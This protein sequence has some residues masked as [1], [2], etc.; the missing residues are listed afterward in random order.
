[1]VGD[2]V[3]VSAFQKAIHAVVKPGHVVVDLGT[4]TGLLAF[5][6]CQAGA[7]KVYAIEREQEMLAVAEAVARANGWTDRIHFLSGHSAAIDIPETADVVVSETIGH[8]GLEEQILH[9]MADAS[10]RFLAPGGVLLP[11]R[12]TLFLVPVESSESW[13]VV[14]FWENDLYGIDFRPA[15]RWA[16]SALQ[17]LS[18]SPESFL[19]EPCCFLEIDLAQLPSPLP[20]FWGAEPTFLA[21]RPG[22]L[23]GLAGWFETELAPGHRLS[24]SPL[25]PATVWQQVF[26]PL[27]KPISIAPGDQVCV[28]FGAFLD[29]RTTIWSWRG[30]VRHGGGIKGAF[31]HSTFQEMAP[32]RP[33]LTRPPERTPLMEAA[34]EVLQ[35]VNGTASSEML[36]QRLVARFPH[37]YLSKEAAL[38]DVFLILRALQW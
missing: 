22:T 12:L 33:R 25:A 36:A 29:G 32:I 15:R 30:Q 16:A 31:D 2:A 13:K 28:S 7:R 27:E 38:A 6:A 11:A 10:A 5:F 34:L 21:L 26:F 4:G 19:A 24:T 20:T 37:R 8:F 35:S 18:V 23:H 17:I 3:R 9:L 14:E 1:M